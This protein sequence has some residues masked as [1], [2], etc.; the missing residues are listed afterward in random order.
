MGYRVRTRGNQW[1]ILNDEGLVAGV[2]LNKDIANKMADNMNKPVKSA[3]KV[4][5]TKKSKKTEKK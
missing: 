1:V 3:K 4:K 5:K 2:F